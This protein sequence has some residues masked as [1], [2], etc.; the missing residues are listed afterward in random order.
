MATEQIVTINVPL[1]EMD[2]TIEEIE[3]MYRDI[4]FLEDVALVLANPKVVENSD[5]PY[6][7]EDAKALLKHYFIEQERPAD[8]VEAVFGKVKD[9]YESYGVHTK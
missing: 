8:F 1:G 6:R 3:K 5:V 2:L 4:Q 7:E 9:V